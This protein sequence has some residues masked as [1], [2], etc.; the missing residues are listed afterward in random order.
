MMTLFLTKK[1]ISGFL[2][3]IYWNLQSLRLYENSPFNCSNWSLKM[4]S[5]VVKSAVCNFSSWG[6]SPFL[7]FSGFFF[8][9]FF[10]LLEF[11]KFFLPPKTT[12]LMKCDSF[13]EIW[14]NV[15]PWY[16]TFSSSSIRKGASLGIK[17][18]KK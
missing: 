5:F 11:A 13:G 7:L 4:R 8:L 16:L 10:P 9:H 2:V 3:H 18:A 17:Q 6:F 12:S 15:D 14:E 1:Q